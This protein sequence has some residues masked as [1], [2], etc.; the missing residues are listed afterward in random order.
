MDSGIS[1][2]QFY[3]RKQALKSWETTRG[4]TANGSQEIFWGSEMLFPT[5]WGHFYSSNLYTDKIILNKDFFKTIP[6]VVLLCVTDNN[7]TRQGRVSG[8]ER[9]KTIINSGNHNFIVYLITLSLLPRQLPWRHTKHK[10]KNRQAKKTEKQKNPK[11]FKIDMSIHREKHT[12]RQTNWQLTSRQT[13]IVL[14]NHNKEV[15]ENGKTFQSSSN[16]KNFIF[17]NILHFLRF[18]FVQFVG[19]FPLFTKSFQR[20]S[21]LHNHKHKL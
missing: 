17:T 14:T 5:F 10:H 12:Q 19:I 21:K 11:I 4:V 9:V 6:F 7:F 20:F 18:K 15:E 3:C 1:R 8:W 2:K 13:Y 16:K